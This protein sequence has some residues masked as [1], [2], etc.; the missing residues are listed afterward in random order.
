ML[1][2]FLENIKDTINT[3]KRF[4]KIILNRKNYYLPIAFFAVLSYGFSIFNRT[5]SIDDLAKIKYFGDD[6][7]MLR[8][9]RWGQY[10]WNSIFSTKA[11]NPNSDKFVTLFFLIISSII[12]SILLYRITKCENVWPYTIFSC[13]YISFGLVNEIWEYTG[14]GTLIWGGISISAFVVL[15]LLQTKKVKTADIIFVSI[16]LTLVVS[17]YESA[18]FVY[19]SIVA[20]SLFL[21]QLINDDRSFSW[22]NKCLVFII[23]LVISVIL[24]YAIGFILIRFYDLTYAVNGET[25]VYW[26]SKSAG[27]CLNRIYECFM[28]YYV[29]NAIYYEPIRLFILSSILFGCIFTIKCHCASKMVLGILSYLSIFLLSFLRGDGLAYRF[30]QT[31]QFFVA[32]VGF[33]VI[34]Y[35]M[36]VNNNNIKKIICITLFG[37]I[38]IRQSL[39]NNQLLVLNNQRSDNEASVIHYLGTKLYSEYDLSKK[40]IFCGNYYLGD[41]IEKQISIDGDMKNGEFVDTNVNSCLRWSVKAFGSQDLM[42]EYFSYYGYDIKTT[43][44]E[45]TAQTNEE[46][47]KIAKNNGMKPLSINDMGDYIL[48]YL[49]EIYD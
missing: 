36:N 46:Y 27:E 2:T 18:I 12:I 21:E 29:Y 4:N 49:G 26:L 40:V 34:Y 45:F 16:L 38:C 39:T 23:P 35:M 42:K 41:Y 33:I 5:I 32:I 13:L 8:S 6:K 11:F 22:L 25:G 20:F 10:F 14:T 24:R 47:T 37:I 28:S 43:D 9:C 3:I 19:V 1:I 7:L 15:Y 17:S 44:E 48:V 30:S 31:I